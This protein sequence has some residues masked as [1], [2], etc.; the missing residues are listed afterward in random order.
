VEGI[1]IRR[2]G[3]IKKFKRIG[4]Q[5]LCGEYPSWVP[6]LSFKEKDFVT[7]LCMIQYWMWLGKFSWGRSV[8]VRRSE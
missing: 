3:R 8:C 1:K 2:F 4:I 6:H 7:F 5:P